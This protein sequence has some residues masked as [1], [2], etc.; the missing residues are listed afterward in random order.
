[1][2]T[3][4]ESVLSKRVFSVYFPWLVIVTTILFYYWLIFAYSID[5]PAA[6][7]YGTALQ[8][9]ITYTGLDSFQEKIALLFRPV[10]EHRIMIPSLMILVNYL[11]T[12]HANF[13]T[14]VVIGNLGLLAIAWLLYKCAPRIENKI[15]FLAPVALILFQLIHWEAATFST[16]A[17]QVFFVVAFSLAAI[18]AISLKTTA[19][20]TA[21]YVAVFLAT[22]TSGSGIVTFIPCAFILAA[23]K[24]YKG[25]VAWLLFF[26]A[27]T[28]VYFYHFV[29]P[30]NAEILDVLNRPVD[31]L[32]SFAA[33][34]G[35][36]VNFSKPW[37]EN[38]TEYVYSLV[39]GIGVLIFFV[40]LTIIK[41]FQRSPAL[42]AFL[43]LMLMTAGMVA[44]S[45]SVLYT[46][47]VMAAV[48]RYKII[49]VSIL[50]SCYIIFVDLFHKRIKRVGAM[51]LI[52]LATVYNY[53][54]FERNFE[55]FKVNIDSVLETSW[56]IH[57]HN[58]YSKIKDWNPAACEAIL[59]ETARLGIYSVPDLRDECL[60]RE[61]PGIPVSLSWD[62]ISPATPA[63]VYDF[64]IHPT[65]S[66]DV[67]GV[68][69]GMAL[70]KGRSPW[71]H[72]LVMRSPQKSYFFAASYI[73]RGD[74]TEKMHA[75]D[76]ADHINYSDCGFRLGAHTRGV[77]PG[78]YEL[79]I[80]LQNHDSSNFYFPAHKTVVIGSR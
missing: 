65:S 9:L 53:K 3:R 66:N 26:A 72:L 64:E 12:G 14:F 54:S 29:N 24:R 58:D 69:R 76:S 2:V 25:L 62:K 40:Y 32:K 77:Q 21:A 68:R 19:G 36:F 35:S 34:T 41:Y 13:Y 79:G 56:A 39:A 51:S 23:G 71:Q 70:E 17:V 44:L 61:P 59:K 20:T 10:G 38:V 75:E 57:T 8:F 11:I 37:E 73:Y 31:L 16:A 15:L 43:L 78:E 33:M 50:A 45:R 30:K 46:P 28:G 55:I 42:Y 7:D 1:M 22:F 49:P 60:R 18:Y 80:V 47:V 52:L 27:V 5:V 63:A 4:T 6:D 74:V 67:V 48:S